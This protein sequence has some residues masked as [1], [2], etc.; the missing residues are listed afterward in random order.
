[1]GEVRIEGLDIIDVLNFVNKKQKKFIAEI[2]A[3]LETQL[4]PQSSE[5]RIVRK[6]ILDGINDY[7]RSILRT[8]LGDVEGLIMK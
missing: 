2:L 4:D 1:M 7:T 6:I 5:Y 8:I 3:E